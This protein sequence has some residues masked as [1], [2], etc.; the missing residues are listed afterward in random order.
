LGRGRMSRRNTLN[1][2]LKEG[3]PEGTDI[4]EEKTSKDAERY[5]PR[6]DEKEEKGS[7]LAWKR[8]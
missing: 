8:N 3:E 4:Q 6:A 2:Y 7:R 1:I 5:R